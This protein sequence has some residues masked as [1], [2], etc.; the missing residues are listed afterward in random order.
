M[1]NPDDRSSDDSFWGRW[2]SRLAT[3]DLRDRWWNLLNFVEARRRLRWTIYGVLAALV[4]F[5]SLGTWF[6]SWW[7][8]RNAISVA[9]QWLAAGRLDIAA[10]AVKE[11]LTVAPE[12][13]EAWAVAAD[14]AVRA[15]KITYAV[16]YARHAAM[17]DPGNWDRAL[18]WAADAVL[19]DL[20]NEANKAL[21]TIPAVAL[22]NSSYGQRIVGELAR[23]KGDLASARAHFESACR[24]DGPLAIDEVPLGI[25]L[26]SA[27]DPAD[28]QRGSTLLEKWTADREWGAQTLRILLADA[29]RHDDRA[30]MLKWADTLRIRPDC[31]VGDMPNCLLALSKADEVHFASA[32]ASL[33][34]SYAT[35]SPDN[36]SVFIGW[37]NQIGRSDEA[38]R[39]AQTL[40]R[41]AA[42]RPPVA[43]AVAEALRQSGK[44]TGLDT[45]TKDGDWK[46]GDLEFLRW[47]YALEAARKLGQTARAGKLWH[48][49]QDHAQLNGVHAVF[50]ADTLYGWGWYDDAV[51]LLWLA[52][53]K[54]GVAM[55]ALGTLARHYQM[56]RDAV[57]QYRAFKRLYT[58]RPEDAD[59]ANNFAF[60][61]AV[62]GNDDALIGRIVRTNH[63]RFP[64]NLNYLATYAFVLHVQNRDTDALALLKPVVSEWKNSTALAFAYGLALAG[65]DQ[66]AGARPVLSTINPATLTTQEADLIKSALN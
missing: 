17:L 62:I 26:L 49:L 10:E 54:P 33:E 13:P 2:R 36:A 42:H 23:Q 51:S 53:D 12:R 60:F 32:L 63:D 58:L 35:T 6:Y 31:A 59:I 64:D 29:L 24:L 22:E 43:V 47:L 27:S 40:P 3:F 52:A 50:A 37:L 25:V 45:W 11:A 56:Q 28:R 18:V 8:D 41:E 44:W 21:A 48:T 66:K 5:G 20:P 65:A 15:G 34:K 46:H 38:L 57:G 61:A 14:F 1:S 30:A 7:R 39:W 16:P 9:R 4:I 55:Q 19:A